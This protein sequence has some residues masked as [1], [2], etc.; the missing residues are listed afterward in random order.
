MKLICQCEHCGQ[1]LRFDEARIGEQIDCPVCGKKTTLYRPTEEPVCC[2]NCG[3][4]QI[5][6]NRKGF[7]VALG[8]ALGIPVFLP[9]ALLGA[10]GMNNIVINCLKC[11]HRWRIKRKVY[12]QPAEPAKD[13]KDALK[14]AWIK[15]L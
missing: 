13:W 2:P 14:K 11:G 9:L 3:S 10:V 1:Q 6:A 8:G 12:A 5:M 7:N 15:S 4:K